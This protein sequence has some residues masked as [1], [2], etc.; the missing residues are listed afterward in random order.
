MPGTWDGYGG[1]A[2]A[3]D[4]PPEVQQQKFNEVW[5]GGAGSSHW[6]C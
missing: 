2:N 3:A 4:A 6:S 1:Y 5:A